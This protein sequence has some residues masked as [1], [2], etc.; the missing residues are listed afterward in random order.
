VLHVVPF[1]TAHGLITTLDVGTPLGLFGKEGD[2]QLTFSEIF[3][4]APGLNDL[5]ALVYLQL[6]SSSLS[7]Q[8][9]R[10]LHNAL[11][12]AVA[13]RVDLKRPLPDRVSHLAAFPDGACA[14]LDGT[15]SGGTEHDDRAVAYLQGA[16]GLQV[17]A[18]LG[19]HFLVYRLN[20]EDSAFVHVLAHR[21]DRL[22]VDRPLRLAGLVK[23]IVL[24]DFSVA[25]L[26]YL[27]P[28]M[29]WCRDIPPTDG[30]SAGATDARDLLRHALTHRV[31]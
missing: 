18:R 31:S 14:L 13:R 15:L 21:D 24:E 29:A 11:V 6:A 4:A 22:L 19:E 17:K 2:G 1:A 10:R 26:V 16:P 25:P 8:E 28:R 9:R 7:T 3:A 12:P 27:E 5:D 30:P 23:R 20:Q